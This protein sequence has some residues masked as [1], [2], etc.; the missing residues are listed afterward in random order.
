[1]IPVSHELVQ[2]QLGAIEAEMKKIGFWQ[3]EALEAEK[4]N[5]K[6]AFAADSMAYPQWLQFVLIPRVKAIIQSKGLFPAGSMVGV[7]AIRE[8]DG[9]SEA[10]GLTDLLC[11]FDRLFGGV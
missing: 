1:M 9:Y 2:Q 10:Q 7:K 6:A 3:N 4:Y 8:F 5:F 11:E